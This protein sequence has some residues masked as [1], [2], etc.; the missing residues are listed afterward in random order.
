MTAFERPLNL[1]FDAAFVKDSSLS[2][3][4][5]NSSKPQRK[6][7]ECWVLHGSPEWS[8]KHFDAQPEWVTKTLLSE[9]FEVTRQPACE[10]SWIMAHRWRYAQAVDPDSTGFF[11]DSE[12]RL[13]VC[14]DWCHGSRVEGAFLSGKAIAERIM[15]TTTGAG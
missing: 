12:A 4:S 3:V 9:F 6:D 5:R 10:A 14:G 2:W 13:G 11:W 15:E 1:P 7:P 8:R